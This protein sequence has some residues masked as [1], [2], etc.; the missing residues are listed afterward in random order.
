MDSSKK[1]NTFKPKSKANENTKRDNLIENI[2]KSSYTKKIKI[3]KCSLRT[4]CQ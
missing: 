1:K 2:L 3:N 4:N